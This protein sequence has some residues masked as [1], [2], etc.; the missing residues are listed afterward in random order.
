MMV[1]GICLGEF[2]CEGSKIVFRSKHSEPWEYESIALLRTPKQAKALALQLN[3]QL[4]RI[5]NNG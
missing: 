3:Q 4:K 5:E 2:Y 1:R